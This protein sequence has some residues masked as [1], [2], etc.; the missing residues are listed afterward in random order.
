MYLPHW[1]HDI[2]QDRNERSKQQ[3]LARSERDQEVGFGCCT[4]LQVIIDQDVPFCTRAIQRGRGI[5]LSIHTQRAERERDAEKNRLFTSFFSYY[6]ET[7]RPRLCSKYRV[8]IRRKKSKSLLQHIVQYEHT[9]LSCL[10]GKLSLL[11]PR[12]L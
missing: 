8:I 2:L 9:V 1:C 11:F 6:L 4:R 10:P 3:I 7:G 5:S 12:C